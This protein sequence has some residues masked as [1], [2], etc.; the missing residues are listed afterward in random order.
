MSTDDPISFCQPKIGAKA[1]IAKGPSGWNETFPRA[2][3]D[4]ALA[5]F[6]GPLVL[7]ELVDMFLTTRQLA[8]TPTDWHT[9]VGFLGRT[10]QIH[11]RLVP[12]EAG[13]AFWARTLLFVADTGAN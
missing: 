5:K 7:D 3:A 8:N 13:I 2:A 10:L 1:Y 11:P 4:L 9:I 6:I 12:H